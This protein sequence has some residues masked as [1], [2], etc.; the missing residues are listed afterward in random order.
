M[1][2]TCLL[3]TGQLSWG[4]L[5]GLGDINNDGVIDIGD[6]AQVGAQWGTGGVP[7]ISADLDGNGLVSV[8]DLAIFG[9]EFTIPVGTPIPPLHAPIPHTFTIVH[10]GNFLD[11]TISPV[12][13]TGDGSENLRTTTLSLVNRTGNINNN[14][15]AYDFKASGFGGITGPLHQHH[16]TTLG[17]DSPLNNTQYSTSIDSHLREQLPA[18]GYVFDPG[19]MAPQEDYNNAPSAEAS[20]APS[21]FDTFGD[22]DFGT[23]LTGTASQHQSI[24]NVWNM[25]RI[26]VPNNGL[27]SVH[28]QAANGVGGEDAVVNFT[29]MVN[30][31]NIN[32]DTAVDIGDLALVGAQWGT[33]GL[34][35]PLNWSAD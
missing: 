9:R 29:F 23:F 4:Q 32:G 10:V 13:P 30:R 26:V 22:T 17:I 11:W 25:A 12:L 19:L 3:V 20:N 14:P 34:G 18:G 24:D 15:T 27:V 8:G 33:N 28:G 35:H 2:V 21:P 16:S 5:A 7:G 31:A 1:V 6:L